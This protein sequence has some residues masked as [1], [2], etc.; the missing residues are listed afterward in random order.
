MI[1]SRDIMS[2]MELISS[3][4][5]EDLPGWVC[6]EIKRYNKA[7]G[8]R[9]DP[10]IEPYLAPFMPLNPVTLY[11]GLGF[12]YVDS[13]AIM[14]KLRIDSKVGSKG[15]Y[16]TGKVQSW[17][18]SKD[19]AEEFA[20]KFIFGNFRLGESLGLILKVSAKPDD[21]LV[22]M[23]NFPSDLKKKCLAFDQDEALLK[24]GNY[25]I[26]VVKLIGGWPKR[27][28]QDIKKKLK[29][30]GNSLLTKTKGSKLRATWNRDPGFSIEYADLVYHRDTKWA[31][32]IEVSI[33]DG[34]VMVQP[35]YSIDWKLKPDKFR[36]EMKPDEIEKYLFS[37]RLEN[38]FMSVHKRLVKDIEKL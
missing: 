18:T 28:A 16:K 10:K 21:I 29:A 38:D 26:E 22:P 32:S 23:Y 31:P 37:G 1:S 15:T 2:D 30:I 13:V 9:L 25:K 12:E 27:D 14:K 3:I 19:Q 34:V 35:F 11:R 17:S 5:E 33:S 36:Y 8:K 20:G 4:T 6:D 7:A 24:P